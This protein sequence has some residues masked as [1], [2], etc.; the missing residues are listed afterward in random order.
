MGISKGY[1]SFNCFPTGCLCLKEFL[2]ISGYYDH[3]SSF[4][5]SVSSVVILL[6]ILWKISTQLAVTLDLIF[7]SFT[8]ESLLS[9]L[10]M[11]DYFLIAFAFVVLVKELWMCFSSLNIS[12]SASLFIQISLLMIV[13]FYNCLLLWSASK[14]DS[15]SIL[16]IL[17]SLPIL[18]LSVFWG[19]CELNFSQYSPFNIIIFFN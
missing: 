5:L 8:V 12:Y 17:I 3:L 15:H 4:A 9:L 6:S 2:D 16:I 10:S 1:L 13:R 14:L 7:H 18:S 11:E 19:S